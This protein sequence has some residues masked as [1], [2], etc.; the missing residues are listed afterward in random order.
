[1]ADEAVQPGLED[2]AR[3]LRL[4]RK[5]PVGDE[6][7]DALKH[8]IITLRLM[9]G[10]SVSESSLCRSTG[11]S[12]TPVRSAIG[13]LTEEGLI[14]VF[15]QR[16]SFVSLISLK[17][18]SDSHFVRRTLEAAILKEAA[19]QWT[20][21]KSA[22]MRKLL[23]DQSEAIKRGEDDRFHELDTRFHELLAVHANLEG[24]WTTVLNM[25]TRVL[26]FYRLFSVPERLPEVVREHRSIIDALDKGDAQR[27]E[28]LLL[29]HVDKVFELLHKVP[30][31]YGPY[32]TE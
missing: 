32:L 7:Y 2:V 26:R 10:T 22:E 5:R 21:E 20:A 4:D 28:A 27:A 3:N 31:A 19:H 29:D 11:V 12:R 1:M 16:G 8:A 6:V 24:A 23:S 13:R 18:I 25:R 30:E 14:D 15:P 9:P 17:N